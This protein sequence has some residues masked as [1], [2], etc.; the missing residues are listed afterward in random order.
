MRRKSWSLRNMGRDPWRADG[1]AVDHIDTAGIPSKRFTWTRALVV[2]IILPT[3]FIGFWATSA[4]ESFVQDFPGLGLHWTVWR[5]SVDEHFVRDTGLLH[6][7]LFAIAV[8]TLRRPGLGRLLGVAWSVYA[9]PHL[10]Y[11]AA[12]WMGLTGWAVVTSLTA[13]AVSAFAGVML[14]VITPPESQPSLHVA[15]D[16]RPSAADHR[17]HHAQ[18]R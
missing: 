2:L 14:I 6:L 3:A 17:F 18:D 12:D 7:A 1:Q 9:V 15:A 13:L 5:G 16:T 10:A 11:H 4:P 8:Q